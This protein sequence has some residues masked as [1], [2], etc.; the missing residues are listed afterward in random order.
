MALACDFEIL[1][2]RLGPWRMQQLHG[3]RTVWFSCARLFSC[4]I[5]AVPRDCE[6]W[7]T[8]MLL[9]VAAGPLATLFG[10]AVAA[11][12]AVWAEPQSW[13]ATFWS[14]LAQF[15]FFSFVLGLMPNG[16]SA[17]VRNDASLFL[18]L[19]RDAPPR[20]SWNSIIG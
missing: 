5:A 11:N 15:H 2:G 6:H 12:A 8:R 10:L 16:E 20:A 9:V 4:S 3:K 14:A 17:K 19:K 18:I 7:R 13:L 1:G